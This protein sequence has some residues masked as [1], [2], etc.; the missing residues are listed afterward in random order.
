MIKR[1]ISEQDQ[2]IVDKDNAVLGIA[3]AGT[4]KETSLVSATTDAVTGG[5]SLVSGGE[6]IETTVEETANIRTAIQDALVN[7]R[8]PYATLPKATSKIIPQLTPVDWYPDGLHASDG[9]Y[10]YGAYS[11][12]ADTVVRYPIG[13]H[14]ATTGAQL[15]AGSTI[16]F[17]APTSIPGLVFFHVEHAGTNSGNI[18][19]ST[20]YGT[21]ASLVLQMG[22]RNTLP[23]VSGA[24]SNDVRWLSNRNFCE[25]AIAGRTVLFI[26]EYNISTSRTI[27]GANDAVC[28]YQSDD[29][30]LTWTIAAEWNTDGNTTYNDVAQGGNYVRHIHGVRYYDGK[31]Y[32]LF[33]DI[34]SVGGVASSNQ[35]SIV[36]WDGMAALVSNV[37]PSSYTGTGLKNLSGWQGYRTCD[38]LFEDDYFY[39]MT[40]ATNNTSN[41]ENPCG[42]F[43]ATYDMA[44][45]ERVDKSILE[46]AQRSGRLGLKHS[47][48]NHLWWDSADVNNVAGAYFN[49]IYTSSSDLSMFARNG[50]LRS[51]TGGVVWAPYSFFEAGEKIYLTNPAG[52]GI[53][54]DGTSVAQFDAVLPWNGERAD[55]LSPVYFVDPLGTDDATTTSRILR[56]NGPGTNAF[57][58]VQYAAT[59]SRVPHGGRIQIAAGTYSETTSINPVWDTTLADTTEYVNFCGAGM[60]A[61]IIGNAS[62]ASAWLFGPVSGAVQ[63]NWD[64][65]DLRLTT[66][67]NA[68]NAILLFRS[69]G[70]TSPFYL[71]FIRAEVGKRRGD[72][73]AVTATDDANTQFCIDWA[74]ATVALLPRLRLVDSNFVFKSFYDTHASEVLIWHNNAAGLPVPQISALRSVFWGGQVQH[75]GIAATMDFQQCVFGGCTNAT[76]HISIL[77]S[78]TVSPTG[79]GNRFESIAATKQINNASGSVT[80]AGQFKGSFC[81]QALVDSTFFDVQ[82]TTVKPGGRVKS[83]YTSDYSI[84]PIY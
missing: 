4:G 84:L 38:L 35:A 6:I 21:T 23:P 67:K 77:S 17:T 68:A 8:P 26:G 27:G 47:N 74:H 13:S 72:I 44:S 9:T 54:K 43:R 14:V 20:D 56:G 25:A 11:A 79:S 42:I 53:G 62:G 16:T 7:T 24:R 70:N 76:G 65:Q 15:L 18:Y 37:L 51:K 52:G 83:P 69:Y 75:G 81:N 41:P 12:S 22:T 40:D 49:S 30:G 2:W 31:V 48:G 59:G 10:L 19:R 36:Q 73:S 1:P 55:T 63:Q 80:G 50:V 39:Y 33:G 82:T 32:V 28:L 71:R 45:V 29:L 46:V 34:G 64:F 61:T 66:F 5:V 60:N 58:T 3:P 78:A 57:K